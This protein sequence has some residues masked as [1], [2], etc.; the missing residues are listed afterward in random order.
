MPCLAKGWE[1]RNDSRELVLFLREGMK[2]S[3]GA[4]FTANDFI[5]WFQDIYGNPEIVPT[6]DPMMSIG[7]KPG[8]IIMEDDY[9]VVFSFVHQQMSNADTV[10]NLVS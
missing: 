2:W 8:E 9:T 5:F 4:P 1:F 3:D 6:P 10:E 7:G